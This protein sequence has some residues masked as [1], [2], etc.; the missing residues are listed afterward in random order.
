MANERQG[1]PVL[2]T[3][4]CHGNVCVAMDITQRVCC[5]GY[6]VGICPRYANGGP[7]W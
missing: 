6:Y 3:R 4:Y 7:G 1:N 5:Y 2:N